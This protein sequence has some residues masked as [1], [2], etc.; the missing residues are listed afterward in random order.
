VAEGDGYAVPL[1]NLFNRQRSKP[2]ENQ[3]G[4]PP[5]LRNTGQHPVFS[6]PRTDD[7]I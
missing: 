3:I 5:N 4:R 6:P 2:S 1:E 7:I